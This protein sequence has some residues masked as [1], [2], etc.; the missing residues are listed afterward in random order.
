MRFQDTQSTPREHDLIMAAQDGDR[1]AQRSIYELYRDRVQNLVY[2]SLGDALF[3][4]DISQ[5]IFLK[6]FRALPDFRF[7]SA[8]ATWIYRIAINECL[9]Q[10]RRDNAQYVP[11]DAILGSVEEIAAADWPDRQQ[12]RQQRQQIIQQA[13]LELSPKLRAV[14]VLKYLEGLSYEEIA[15]VLDCSTGTVASRLSRALTRLEARLRPFR[16]VL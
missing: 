15:A 13:V 6:I 5:V 8:L 4:E 12:E 11:L 9:N 7:E 1:T 2:Y 14:V 3:A 10:S 16:T